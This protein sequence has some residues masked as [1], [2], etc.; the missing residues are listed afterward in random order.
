MDKYKNITPWIV[1]WVYY[2]WTWSGQADA[3]TQYILGPVSR[4][5]LP[6]YTHYWPHYTLWYT[7]SFRYQFRRYVS[8]PWSDPISYNS[9]YCNFRGLVLIIQSLWWWVRG[10]LHLILLG[11]FISLSR[12]HSRLVNRTLSSLTAFGIG[13]CF[14][15]GWIFIGLIGFSLLG[16]AGCGDLRGFCLRSSVTSSPSSG[17]LR[18][19]IFSL[20]ASRPSLRLLWMMCLCLIS[21]GCSFIERG[22]LF[23]VNFFFFHGI[24]SWTKSPPIILFWIKY[25]LSI[26]FPNLLNWDISSV[27]LP[28]FQVY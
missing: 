12:C 10:D 5:W 6:Y 28:N 13:G 8:T 24:I 25:S 17:G 16:R 20:W 18:M 1:F 22:S 15:A 21:C 26:F 4:E 9:F 7:C 27:Y 3:N 19:P 11:L 23:R 14:I 2:H